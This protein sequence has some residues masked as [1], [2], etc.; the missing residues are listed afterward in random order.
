[1]NYLSHFVVEYPEQDPSIISGLVFPDAFHAIN[2]I[3]NVHLRNL[4]VE[5]EVIK[6][7]IYGMERHKLADL[8]FHESEIFKNVCKE[9]ELLLKSEEKLGLTRIFYLAHI[10]VELMMDRYLVIHQREKADSLYLSLEQFDVIHFETFI[11]SLGFNTKEMKMNV[12]ITNFVVNRFIY[13]LED[14]SGVSRVLDFLYFKVVKNGPISAENIS[15]WYVLLERCYELVQGHT[16]T[17]IKEVKY[18][19]N[20]VT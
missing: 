15:L 9:V 14:I 3:Y 19:V 11:S 16:E 7:F 8:V 18:K 2:K 12:I 13:R 10:L 6:K 4:P 20:N 1:M 5:D 17:L